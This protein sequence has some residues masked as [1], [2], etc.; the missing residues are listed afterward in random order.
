MNLP[1]GITASLSYTTDDVL[2]DLVANLGGGPTGSGL[3]V[4]QQNVANALNNFFN[5][6]GA[7]PPNFV[8]VFSL[9]GGNLANALTQLDG[10]VATGAERSAFQIMTQFLGLML[11]PFV[12]GRSRGFGGAGGAIGFAPEQQA[13]LPPDIAL[14]YSS[15]LTKAPPQTFDQRWTAWGSAY[16]GSNSANGNATVGSTNVTAQTYGFAAGMDYHAT[17]NTIFG[18]ALAGGGTNWGLAN[19]LG[20]G[21]SDALQAGVYGITYVGPAYFAGALAFTNHWFTTNRS[22]LGN[23]L[24]ANFDAQSYG[25]RLEGGYRFGV[26]P[27][28]GVTPYMALQAQDF[29][30]PAYSESDVASGGFGLS[31]AAMNATD[32]R[33][34][35]G[36]RFDA[37]TLIAGMPLILRGRVAWAHDFVSNPALSAAFETLPGASFT[38]SGAPIPHDSA[39]T[40]AGAEWFITPRW[41]LLAKFDGEFANGS[42][43][44]AGTGTVRYVW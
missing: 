15:I 34:E 10:E 23:E 14:A 42:Q 24:T 37:P 9:T 43:T 3:N 33:T 27:T 39:L 16:G 25:A 6:G 12:D 11:D 38:V 20:T 40:S 13:G 26:L 22:A 44:Y 28:L 29:H 19:A 41:T 35:I 18:F 7:L 17:P 1:P 8:S 36:S 4:N 5:S 32:V 31:Y 21:R 30:T 2:L